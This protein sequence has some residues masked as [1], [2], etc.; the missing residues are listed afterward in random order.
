MKYKEAWRLWKLDDDQRRRMERCMN[1]LNKFEAEMKELRRK[2]KF[3]EYAIVLQF[4]KAFIRTVAR[5]HGNSEHGWL[6]ACRV[7]GRLKRLVSEIGWNDLYKF[8][9]SVRNGRHL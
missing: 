3:A 8:I 7:D 9:S 6:C 5:Y 1:R 4:D 2:A